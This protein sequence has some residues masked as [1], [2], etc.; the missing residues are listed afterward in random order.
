M[1]EGAGGSRPPSGPQGKTEGVVKKRSRKIKQV[2]MHITIEI[3]M[4]SE[5]KPC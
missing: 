1:Q 4:K 5:I 3:T 2:E